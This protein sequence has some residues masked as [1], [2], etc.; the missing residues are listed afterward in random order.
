MEEIIRRLTEI[1]VRQQQF[2]E[3]LAAR[4]ERTEQVVE[5]LRGATAQR[6]PLPEPRWQAHQHL[7]KLNDQDDVEAYLHTFEV[8]ATREAWEKERWA[9]LL[10]PFLTGEAQRAY[11]SLPPPR[12]EDYDALKKEILARVGLS[13]MCA[14][15]HFQ[16]WT[17]DEHLTIRAQAARLTRLAHL[18]LL[19]DGPTVAQ[20]A[21]RVVIDRLLRALPRHYRRLVNMRNPSSLAEL[22]EA[23]EL[24]EA[25]FAPEAGDRV[26]TTPRKTKLDRRQAE[27]T[28]RPVNGPVVPAPGQTDEP[29]PTEP[30][31]PGGRV[32]KA[33]CI[34]HRAVP[35]GAPERTVCLDGGTVRAVL[36]SGS[37]ITLVQPGVLRPRQSGKARIPITCVHGDTRNVP[38]QRVTISAS[39]GTWQLEVG[40]VKDLPVPVLLGRDWPGFDQLMA[41]AMQQGPNPRARHKQRAER[42]EGRRPALLATDSD[43]DGEC[44]NSTNM[45]MNLFQQITAGGSFG[46]EQ[47]EDE[48]LKNCWTQVRVIEEEVR[49]PPPHPTPY[50][51]IKNGLLYCVAQHRGEEKLLLVVPRTKTE[52]VIELAHSHPM[53]GHL[54]VVNTTQR[55]R[56]R[57]H[58]PGLEAEVKR[59]CQSCPTCQ[60]TSPRQPPPSPLVPLPIIEV[61]FSRIGMDLVGPLPKSARGH[62]HILVILDY[63]T[64]YPE[65]VPLRKATSK[66]IARE[67]FMLFSRVGIPQ[68][69]LTDQGTPFMS[70]LMAELC[71]LLKVK[72]LRTSVYHPQTDGLVERFNQTLKQMLRRVVAE[73]G[74]DWD[75]MLPYVLF[76]IR[77]VPQASTGFTPFEL[78]FGRQPRGLL[79]VARE[80]WEQQPAPHR[81]VIEHVREMRERIERVMPLVREHLAESQRAQKR[82]YD[83]PAQPREFQ[84]GDRVLVLVPTATSKFLASWQGPY[85]IIEKV[86]PVTYRVR[87]VGRRK[88]QQIYHINLLK[89]W[90]APREQLAAFAQEE[91]PVVA[92][93]EQLSP[94]QKAEITTLVRQFKD[95]F[96]TLPGQTRIIQHEIRTPPGEIIRQ[97]PYRIPEA[98]RQAIEE[99]VARMHQLGIIEP[100]RSPWS[101]PIVMVPKKDGTLRFC[102]DFRRL[103]EISSF[104]GY[105]MPRVDELL[106]RLGG[107]RYI[108][109][110]D[111][112]KGYWQVPLTPDSKEKTAFSTPGGHWHYRV[113]PFGLH[114]APATFQR[115]MDIILRPHQSYAAAYLDDVVI[116]SVSWEEHLDRLRRVLTELRRAGLTANPKKCHL[117]LAEAQYLGYQIGRGLIRPQSRKIEAVQQAARPTNKTQVRAFLGLAG[118]YRCFIPNFSSIASP[119]TDLTKKGQPEKLKWTAA[120]EAAFQTLKE[121]LSSSPVL[122]APDFSCPFILQ[123]DAS[124]TGLGAVLSQEKGGEE[125]PVVYISRKLTPAE[126]RYA[127]VEKEALAIKWAILELR[128]YLLGRTFTLITDHAPLQWMARAKDTNARITRWFLALQDFHFRVQ[129]RAGAAHGNAD[130]L[131]RMWSLW[132]GLSNNTSL[133]P[134]RSP[135]SLHRCSR[136]TRTALWGGSVVSQLTRD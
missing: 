67:L 60:R 116:H 59:F 133:P 79:D 107:A 108:S 118:Y 4:Q 44:A 82:L 18:W 105:P 65:A 71:Q 45:Y 75:L 80:A 42:T 20:V 12:N 17:Y 19:H 97:R 8:I 92:V 27:G 124:D 21:E 64:R 117:G 57:F 54:G 50:F 76:G 39:P 48:R 129:H 56:D 22:M 68:E 2:S 47:R 91:T 94:M 49:Q 33:G 63:A 32:W 1:T 99:E 15:R 78:L 95:V 11:Y 86:G 87:Q 16:Q 3:Q 104:D 102:N 62:E 132:S 123:T 58:W 40:V 83:R 43:G 6:T 28:S 101:S 89:R 31:S 13:P 106:V 24:A 135:L 115:M 127:A 34:V 88:E 109:T 96:N 55:I 29:M 9:Q 14:A 70:Q 103:N 81:T 134:P 119:L 73:D 72:Q 26:A 52:T 136:S 36:D 122:H 53:S 90:V 111:L 25:S 41:T 69:I 46:R 30:P 126:T 5:Q 61:P 113:L 77:E 130:G 38:A 93:G 74:R 7:T 131:S 35:Q 84:P 120:A 128:Y 114:G 110:L 66:A 121:A 37:S 125:H 51:I 23:V 100:S 98:R 85:T 112:T 10:A